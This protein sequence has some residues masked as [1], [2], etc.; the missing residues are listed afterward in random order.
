MRQFAATLAFALLPVGALAQQQPPLELPFPEGAAYTCTQGPSRCNGGSSLG[1]ICAS[2]TDCPRARCTTAKSHIDD[3]DRYDLDFALPLGAPVVAVG[4]GVAHTH[5]AGPINGC[6]RRCVGGPNDG[7]ICTQASAC[8]AGSCKSGNFGNNVNLDHGSGFFTLYAHLETISVT[9]GQHVSKGDVIGLADN[10]GYSCGDHLHFGLHTGD[11]G[12]DA[13]LSA[14]VA[15]ESLLVQDQTGQFSGM[16]S[17]SQMVCGGL[18]HVYQAIR[19][20]ETMGTVSGVVRYQDPNLPPPSAPVEGVTVT[21]FSLDGQTVAG[22]A[23]TDAS[24]RY[25]FSAPPGIYFV[26][27]GKNLGNSTFLIGQAEVTIVAA[28]SVVQ[29]IDL[30]FIAPL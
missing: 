5:A 17:I 28:A 23:M 20:P 18:G 7:A 13:I 21:L 1:A 26:S 2:D 29:D 4:D 11:P 10:T 16:V 8:P 3:F 9:D 15:I 6:E 25:S 30:V 24:G 12:A 14:S 22:P 19:A 27:A